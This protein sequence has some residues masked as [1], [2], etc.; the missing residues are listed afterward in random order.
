VLSVHSTG[1]ADAQQHIRLLVKAVIVIPVTNCGALWL[2]VVG[3]QHGWALAPPRAQKQHHRLGDRLGHARPVKLAENSQVGDG[4]LAHRAV[5][6]PNVQPLEDAGGAE[7]VAALG[8]GDIG[9]IHGVDADRTLGVSVTTG[10]V[11]RRD[12]PR[13][14]LGLVLR[15][16]RRRRR[17]TL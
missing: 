14:G 3:R 10:D 17:R 5:L 8:D 7:P 4:G 15:W 9:G 13:L 16:R 1:R 2:H 12:C 11:D 6:V